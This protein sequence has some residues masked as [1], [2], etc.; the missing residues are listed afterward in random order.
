MVRKELSV[1][2]NVTMVRN[3]LVESFETLFRS[4]L[5]NESDYIL[6][7]FQEGMRRICYNSPVRTIKTATVILMASSTL[8]MI[9]LTAAL[10]HRSRIRGLS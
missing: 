9:A 5:L 6:T 1:P 2:G 10:A 8:P 7:M 3:E 4:S